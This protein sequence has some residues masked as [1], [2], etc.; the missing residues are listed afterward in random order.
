MQ[1]LAISNRTFMITVWVFRCSYVNFHFTLTRAQ[2]VGVAIV[3]IGLFKHTT[4][5]MYVCEYFSMYVK[6][7]D[8][9]TRLVQ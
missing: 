4:V 2:Q 9:Q 7:L 1:Y 6:L 8:W 3:P 5:Y